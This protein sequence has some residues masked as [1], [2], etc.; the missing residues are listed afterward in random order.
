MFLKI[1]EHN[2]EQ[3]PYFENS[4]EVLDCQNCIGKYSI[5]RLAREKLTNDTG[6]YEFIYETNN[7]GL[8]YFRQTYFPHECIESEGH[9]APGYATIVPI[10]GFTTN[11]VS[12]QGLCRRTLFLPEENDGSN[13]N[14][15]IDGCPQIANWHYPIGQY[16]ALGLSYI[17]VGDKVEGTTLVRLWVRV[18]FPKIPMNC[19]TCQASMHTLKRFIFS[20]IFVYSD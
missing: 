3:A 9:S 11:L 8:H 12:F 16:A 14:A 6:S 2:I 10:P 1:Y 7:Y 20:Q 19:K 4:E 18:F 15:Y 5:I 17:P 13:P